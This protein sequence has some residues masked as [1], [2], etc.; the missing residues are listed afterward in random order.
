MTE[1]VIN[2]KGKK[3][4]AKVKAVVL[5]KSTKAKTSEKFDAFKALASNLQGKYGDECGY[6]LGDKPVI[7]VPKIATGIPSL[8]DALRGGVPEGRILEF[9]GGESCGKTTAAIQ[10]AAGKQAKNPDFRVVFIDVESSLDV[11]YA[12]NLGLDTKSGNTMHLEPENGEQALDMME[13]AID[14]KSVDLV[15]LDSISALVPQ[16][17]LEGDMGDAN[18]GSQA[19]LMSQAYRKLVAKAKRS[20]TTLI[21]VNQERDNLK[22]PHGGSITTGGKAT[23]Y[24]ASVR[25]Q[26]RY[27]GKIEDTI[28]KEKV[29]IGR[30]IKITITKNK[31]G[32]HAGISTEVP[33]ITDIGFDCVRDLINCCVKRG[34]INKAG[35]WLSYDGETEEKK[36]QGLSNAATELRS[37]KKEYDFLLKKLNEYIEEGKSE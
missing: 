13:M 35:A 8:D 28:N 20:N 14:S 7:R 30:N 19:K 33:V 31:T 3:N 1:L 5:K 37:N 24:Y 29:Q 2:Q 17:E 9:Y 32:G 18:Y 6:V 23:K 12:R 11:F 22:S 26:F 15:I 4:A 25:L 36:F 16:K 34:I 27:I 10:I 21:L